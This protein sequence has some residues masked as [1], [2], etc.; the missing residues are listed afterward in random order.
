M[1]EQGLVDDLPSLAKLEAK[2]LGKNHKDDIIDSVLVENTH[3]FDTHPS[4]R[5]R[6]AVAR[7][8]LVQGICRLQSS[9]KNI[10]VD[11][12]DLSREMT[13]KFYN[14]M[15]EDRAAQFRLLPLEQYLEYYERHKYDF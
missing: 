12:S 2:E 6:I 7:R 1:K 4:C 14:E 11:F 9:A 10:F 3:L 13:W 5:D 15:L 8:K